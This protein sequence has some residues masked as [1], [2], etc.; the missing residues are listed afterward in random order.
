MGFVTSTKNAITQFP[1]ISPH[2]RTEA[3]PGRPRSGQRKVG[4][5]SSSL[6]DAT[7]EQTH[8]SAG[9]V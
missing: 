2:T 7:H 9:P 4:S 5:F 3:S 1:L 6:L 8:S